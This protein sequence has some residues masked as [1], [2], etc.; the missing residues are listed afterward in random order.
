MSRKEIFEEMEEMLGLVP[1]F[2]KKLPDS[3]LEVEWELF[4]KTEIEESA[5][6]S[7]YRELIGVGVSAATRCRYCSFY[8]TEMAK[9]NGASE[10]EIEDAV[11]FA[12][13]T[14]GW[15]TYVNGLQMDEKEFK[16]EV[17]QVCEFVR[18]RQ[19]AE[20]ELR[21]ADIGEG[22]D[23]V[24]R[25][26]SEEEILIKAKEHARTEHGEEELSEEMLEKARGAIHSV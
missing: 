25:G 10:E 14:T 2:F 16:E 5:I 26:K 19:G 20:K 9:L 22:C 24:I 7:K 17:K 18:S 12:K 15:S 6:P 13:N 23:F 4:K 21:C 1:G 11:H 8:H 3:T